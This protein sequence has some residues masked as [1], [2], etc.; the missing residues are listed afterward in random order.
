M[1][2]DTMAR[3]APLRVRRSDLD[4]TPTRILALVAVSCA[5]AFVANLGPPFATAHAV[6]VGALAIAAIWSR[7]WDRALLIVAF[8]PGSELVWRVTSA[9]VFYEYAKYVVIITLLVFIVG[10]LRRP[11][12]LSLPLC[13]L[14]LLVPS[15][16]IAFLELGPG[17]ARQTVAFA[18][19]GP[20]ALVVGVIA[21]HD[22]R[23]ERSEFDGFLWA[24]AAGVAGLATATL[25]A[26]VTAGEIKFTGESNFVTAGGFGPV[27]V[28]SALAAGVLI[29]AVLAIC[30]RRTSMRL[31]AGMLMLWFGAQSALTFSRGGLTS[32]GIALLVYALHQF[33]RPQDAIRTVIVVGACAAIGLSVIFPRIDDFTGGALSDR[34]E[35]R[36]SSGRTSIAKQDIDI[37]LD[38]TIAGVGPGSSKF[39]RADS[40]AASSHTEFTRLLAEHGLLGLAAMLLLLAIAAKLY[41]RSTGLARRAEVSALLVWA[42]SQM[43][44]AN[45]RV[46]AVA[47]LFAAAALRVE[48][49]GGA[50]PKTP[51]QFAGA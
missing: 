50:R 11:T 46:V 8:V 21:M 5:A 44:Y 36:S 33:W 25:Y 37:F 51:N 48:N 1:S 26:T 6:V 47:V 31:L 3:E 13:Y 17:V 4:L 34:F 38:H 7:R 10:A 22:V 43:F 40:I 20:T 9:W 42:M 15:A 27:Q 35:E 24:F 14:M 30:E 23:L 28:S 32:A 12:F 19:A 16:S 2:I 49:H 39:Y 45:L 41:L 29:C 18:L